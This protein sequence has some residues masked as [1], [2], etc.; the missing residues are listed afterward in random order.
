M[1]RS[2]SPS[3]STDRYRPDIDGLR[4]IAVLGVVAFHIGIPG[5]SGG[6]VGVDIFFVISGY[7]ISGLLRQELLDTGE[8][9]FRAFYARRFRRLA[10][11]LLLM[12]VTA[13]VLAYFILLPDDQNKLG[14][15][16]RGIALLSANLHFLDHAFD[17]FNAT[18]DLTVMLHTWSLAVEE[19]YYLAWPLLLWG[20]Y[21]C[22]GRKA[23]RVISSL[24]FVLTFILLTSL[25]YCLWESY[26]ETPRAFYLMP[27][28]AWEFA[29]G[30]LA[31]ILPWPDN[32]KR[33]GNWMGPAGMLLLLASL[34]QLDESMTFPGLIV[35]L[36][37]CGSVLFLLAGKL[38]PENPA[39]R[40]ASSSP[41]TMIGLLSYSFYLWHWPLLALGRYWGLGER[42][43]SRDLLLGG[44]LSLLLSWF[45]YRFVEQ[46]IRQKK[47]KFLASTASTLKS[48]FCIIVGMWLLGNIA[49]FLLPR[50]PWP[51]HE[52]VMKAK[53][54]SM[55]MHGNC[56]MPKSGL[57]LS[58]RAECLEGDRSQATKLLAWGDSHTDHS[59]PMYVQLAQQKHIS[60]LRR[61]YHGCPPLPDVTPI[62]EGKLRT[63]CT[64]FARAVRNEL[65]DLKRQGVSGVLMNV[66]WN[67]YAVLPVPG[68]N[69]VAVMASGLYGMPDSVWNKLPGTP[70][71][72]R[73]TSLQVLQQS[74]MENAAYMQELGLK[75]VLLMP[76]P[77]MPRSV[78]ECINRL[79]TNACNISR[80]Q[81]EARRAPIVQMLK[82][83]ASHY[84]NVRLWDA[85]PHFC[86][87]NTCYA[88][89]KGN[90]RY[91]DQNHITASMARSMAADFQ[92]PFDWALQETPAGVHSGH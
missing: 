77:E 92:A 31:A 46:P 88:S 25:G 18:S 26:H 30:A 66:R 21:R 82:T 4:A 69:P 71:L 90:I 61:V 74:L 56:A 13:L 8:I 29:A 72:D 83:V 76:E 16:I 41:F 89:M 86:D 55:A 48:G 36:P 91:Q 38:N 7:L 81:A 1:F 52:S 15:E 53:Q 14:R 33:H 80:Q 42:N 11:A 9:N 20:I 60:I 22:T 6:F 62:G 35:L 49:M 58:P 23:D 28:R 34:T 10:P 75:L 17:Y 67:G 32:W 65:P 54:D 3:I 59:M 40:L 70:P 87:S 73:A 78:P 12:V 68:E 57:P 5:L 79:G 47:L 27:A 85:F 64:N 37:V 50:A 24:P 2:F 84:D 45:S 63:W 44:A 51:G 39:N 43:L 19:Q